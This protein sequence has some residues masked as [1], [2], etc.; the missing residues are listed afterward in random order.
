MKGQSHLNES[1]IKWPWSAKAFLCPL[2]FV[3]LLLFWQVRA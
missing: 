2:I 1:E 3:L